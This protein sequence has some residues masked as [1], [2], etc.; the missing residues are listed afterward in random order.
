V[1]VGLA[2]ASIV[3]GVETPAFA[4]PPT[5]TSFSPTRGPAGC[6]VVIKGSNFDNPVASSVDIGG[7]SVSA[8]KIVSATHDLGDRRRHD[9]WD[10]PCHQRGRYSEQP[11][12]FHQY[13]S[14]G[15]LPIHHVVDAMFRFGR[16]DCGDRWDE[17][18]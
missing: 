16:D 9:E 2:A 12:R 7:T 15:L 6:V 17:S 18:S 1:G 4:L 8:F 11:N 14:G 13:Q 5:I 10:H 3:I